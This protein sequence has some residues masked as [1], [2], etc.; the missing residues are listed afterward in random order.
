MNLATAQVRASV[1]EL[2]RYP[3]FSLSALLF[4]SVLFLIF[5]RAY[6]QPANTRM[7][8][9]AAIA[10]LGVLFF[11][12]G[13]GIAADRVSSWEAYLRTLPAG[14]RLR[15]AARICA[16]LVFAGTAAT[17]VAVVAA[18][19]TPVGMPVTRWLA[20]IVAL[21]LGAVPFGLL[22][23]AIGYLV[24]PRAALPIAN[25]LYLPLSYVGGLWAGPTA[26]LGRHDAWLDLVPTHAW[27]SSLWSAVGATSFDPAAP[28]LLAVWTVVI[29]GVAVRAYRRDE[30]ERFS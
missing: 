4:P 23:I 2:L 1:L 7:A 16:A 28:A 18:A 25:L 9:F 17:V 13:V 12:F 21:T 5:V 26:R 6:P 20:L 8:G 15:F 14:P 29:G 19:T 11:Q 10:V 24:R 27:A 22:G 30:G 3:S